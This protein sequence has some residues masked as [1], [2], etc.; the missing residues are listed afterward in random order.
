MSKPLDP[1]KPLWQFQ[2]VDNY[3]Q[4]TAL[5]FRVHHCIADGLALV[6]LLLSV[7]DEAPDSTLAGKSRIQKKKK[8]S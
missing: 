1:T 2:Y 8:L 7:A 6:K 3:Y 4:H 5:I